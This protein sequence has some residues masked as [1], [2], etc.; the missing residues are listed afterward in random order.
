ML[1]RKTSFVHLCTVEEMYG[2]DCKSLQLHLS[3]WFPYARHIRC[4]TTP[5]QLTKHTPAKAG[6]QW[7]SHFSKSQRSTNTPEHLAA[8][9]PSTTTTPSIHPSHYSILQNIKALHFP[10]SHLRLR[11]LPQTW[12]SLGSFSPQPPNGF[13]PQVA[14]RMSLMVLSLQTRARRLVEQSTPAEHHKGRTMR[15]RV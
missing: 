5:R 2:V 12:E 6:C 7:G 8:Y 14:T 13:P 15:D 3:F 11:P 4:A 1:F 10:H 9:T